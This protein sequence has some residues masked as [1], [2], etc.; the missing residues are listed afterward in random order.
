[1]KV[2]DKMKEAIKR[3][4]KFSPTMWLSEQTGL[5]YIGY[6]HI[7]PV[8]KVKEFIGVK[9]TK[10]MAEEFR[11]LCRCMFWEIFAIWIACFNWQKN[12]TLQ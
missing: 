8:N 10:K 9:I 1:M 2:S 3:S 6:G 5:Y 11:L 7:I 4:R 12:I